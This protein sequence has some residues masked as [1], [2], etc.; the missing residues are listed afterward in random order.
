MPE[1]ENGY[2]SR[3][4]LL[5]DMDYEQMILRIADAGI[6]VPQVVEF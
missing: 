2:Y 3:S 4:F 6:V 1:L 5:N